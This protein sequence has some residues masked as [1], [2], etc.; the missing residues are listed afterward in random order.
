MEE[1]EKK[2]ASFATLRERASRLIDNAAA[3]KEAAEILRDVEHHMAIQAVE[4]TRYRKQNVRDSL[5]FQVAQRLVQTIAAGD[6]EG[7]TMWTSKLSV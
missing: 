6:V 5:L 7:T 4:L 3:R 2:K 1:S